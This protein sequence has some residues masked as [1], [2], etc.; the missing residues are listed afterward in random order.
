[1]VRDDSGNSHII[2][3]DNNIPASLQY[4]TRD[5]AGVWDIERIYTTMDYFPIQISGSVVLDDGNIPHIA[6]CDQGFSELYYGFRV[7]SG[8]NCGDADEWQCEKLPYSCRSAP[9]IALDENNIPHISFDTRLPDTENFVLMH[10][11]FEPVNAAFSGSPTSGPAPLEVTFTNQSTGSFDT[12]TWDFGD[13]TSSAECDPLPHTYSNS[14]VYSVS[15]TVSGPGGEDT[16]MLSDYITVYELA[17]AEFVGV[18]TSGPAPLEVTFTNQST[19]EFDTCAWVFGDGTNSAECNPPPH[20]YTAPGVYSVALT[21]SGLGGE[22][23]KTRPNYITV[24]ENS[25]YLIFLPI[26]LK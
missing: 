10:V 19:G 20:T 26:L 4:V 11:T 16:L 6:F 21:V 3:M 23:T 15:L 2:F 8:G 18:P 25:G 1:M 12:C 14:G 13:G 5:T 9:S 22:D 7:G 17:M 24:E